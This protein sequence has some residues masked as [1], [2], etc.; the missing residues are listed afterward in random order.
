MASR[1]VVLPRRRSSLFHLAFSILHSAFCS[2]HSRFRLPPS[3]VPAIL[4]SMSTDPTLP[5]GGQERQRALEMSLHQEQPPTQVPG[6]EPERFLGMGAYGEVWVAIE[7]NTGRRVAIKFYTHRGGLDWSLLSRE[8][9]KLAFLFAIATS[10]NSSAWVGRPSPRI[11]S[12]SI[13]STARWPSGSRRN[14]C[15]SR[16]RWTCFAM[17]RSGLGHAHAK[18]VLHCDLKPANI[19]LD[20][21]NKPRRP[22]SANRDCRTSRTRPWA[23]CSTW[24]PSRP[25]WPP[26]R[27][28]SGTCMPWA[29]CSTR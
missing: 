12:W 3:A 16:R 26:C 10:C 20:Q 11:T 21:D 9:E 6:Y 14:P 24:P 7:R 8:V 2:L 15:R 23:R 28:S 1:S 19:L 5:Q 17:W 25:T 4:A 18:G 13:W 27:T 29:P 22:I